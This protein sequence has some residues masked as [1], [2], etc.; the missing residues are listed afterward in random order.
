MFLFAFAYGAFYAE[1][2]GRKVFLD[3]GLQGPAR[4]VH[5]DGV[6]GASG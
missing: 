1:A 4:S 5:G 2:E 6:P 3:G